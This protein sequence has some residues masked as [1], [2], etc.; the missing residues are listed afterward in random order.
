MRT[1]FSDWLKV[2]FALMAAVA[3]SGV[4]IAQDTTESTVDVED[5]VVAQDSTDV[6]PDEAKPEKKISSSAKRK[7]KR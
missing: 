6:T 4:T 3:I 7:A 5:K 2:S 1:K